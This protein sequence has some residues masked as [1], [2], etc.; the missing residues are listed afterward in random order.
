MNWINL[1]DGPSIL[2]VV[3]GT[4][5][6][7]ILRCGWRDSAETL[8]AVLGIRRK[9]FDADAVR[10]EL[11][12][13]I[14][15]IRQDGF[16]RAKAHEFGD[17]EFDDAAGALIDQRSVAALLATHEAHKQRRL[18]HSEVGVR[19]LSQA[20][21]LAPVFGLAGTL[22]S[23]TQLPTTGLSGAG[24]AATIS[25][26]VLTTLYGLLLCNLVLAPMARALHRRSAEEEAERQKIV[27]WLADQMADQIGGEP[28]VEGSE[29]AATG[30][31][32]KPVTADRVAA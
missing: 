26:A 27:D 7:T 17:S 24:Y 5:L 14:Q 18:A 3:A 28:T 12:V 9:K 30:G 19:T 4:L 32:A 15:E 31:S 21:E 20:A 25:M 1:L 16:V 13:Q 10:S 8:S 22:L 2:I 23:L 6:A 11:G 29:P